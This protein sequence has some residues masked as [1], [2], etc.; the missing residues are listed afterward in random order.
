MYHKMVRQ[1]HRL[2][3]FINIMMPICQHLADHPLFVR[4]MDLLHRRLTNVLARELRILL[5]DMPEEDLSDFDQGLSDSDEEGV[6]GDT[7]IELIDEDP[8]DAQA[9][10]GEEVVE[11]DATTVHVDEA[12]DCSVI[13]EDGFAGGMPRASSPQPGPS[14]ANRGAVSLT[15]AAADSTC[16]EAVHR[17]ASRVSDTSDSSDL[18]SLSLPDIQSYKSIHCPQRP[19]SLPPRATSI[20]S[21]SSDNLTSVSHNLPARGKS[22]PPFPPPLAQVS[23]SDIKSASLD[24]SMASDTT[25]DTCKE[26]DVCVR[27]VLQASQ[28]RRPRRRR[29]RQRWSRSQRECMCRVAHWLVSD[30]DTSLIM[31]LGGP[32]NP[33]VLSGDSDEDDS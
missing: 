17:P 28:R 6:H 7:T 18:P 10:Q 31:D 32:N 21:V 11:L 25:S 9:V 8:G 15:R 29:Y 27:A 14:Y 26:I 24:E 30:C 16:T 33:I 4:R 5:E 12:G 1:L 13:S 22:N 20:L 2:V 23:L 3:R 19:Q